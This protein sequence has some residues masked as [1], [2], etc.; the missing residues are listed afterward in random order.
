M[1]SASCVVAQEKS[2]VKA[3]GVAVLSG[4]LGALTET[5]SGLIDGTK[6]VQDNKMIKDREFKLILED[7]QYDVPTAVNIFNRVLAA[8]PKNELLFHMGYM[9][10]VLHAIAEKVK[11][12]GIVCFDVTTSTDIFNDQVREKYPNYFSVGIQYGDQAGCLLKYIKTDLHKSAEKP[13]VAFIYIDGVTGK[14]PL[15]KMA[16][17][18]KQMDI[19]LVLIEPV[20]FETTDFAPT[21]MKIRS[22]QA[23]YVI[24]WS[25]SIGVS[26]RFIKAARQ[27]VPKTKILGMQYLAWENLHGT[28][29]ASFDGVYAISPYP[30]PSETQNPF[31]ARLLA[32]ANKQQREIKI[33]DLYVGGYLMSLMSGEAA[34]R[35]EQAGDLSRSGA[36]KALED[37][38]DWD[39][40]GMYEGKSMDFGSHRLPRAR[41]LQAHSESKSLKPVTDWFNIEEYLK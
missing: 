4:K 18:A 12:T 34:K 6:D 20:T 37:L 36:R 14:D 3:V 24:L 2:P 38:K 35:A 26:T 11:E 30:R 25:W 32:M 22:A 9:T 21:V 8:E 41:I 28:L 33:W 16:Q 10:G 15:K 31:V 39:I 27:Y 29:G 7:G 40:F 13:K 19:D 5:G 1:F 17:Y 23:D